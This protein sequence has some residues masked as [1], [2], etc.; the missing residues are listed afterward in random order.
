MCFL[1]SVMCFVLCGV[2]LELF[3][4]FYV[5]CVI[6]YMLCVIC[7]VLHVIFYAVCGM[8]YMLFVMCYVS[9]VHKALDNCLKTV[10][11]YISTFLIERVIRR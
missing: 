8:C 6:A 11:M 10:N 3:V 4:M 2:C 9:Y 7:F 5:L 1:F